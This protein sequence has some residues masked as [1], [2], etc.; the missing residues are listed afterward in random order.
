LCKDQYIKS[1][2]SPFVLRHYAG[3]F[4][5]FTYQND[6]RSWAR[7]N[8]AYGVFR[9]D[10]HAEVEDDSMWPWLKDFVASEGHELAS[11][12]LA[13]VGLLKPKVKVSSE[14][15]SMTTPA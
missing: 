4:D 1:P 15:S 12:L 2:V 13:D 8:E 7:S 9:A 5:Q 10:D 3:T 6:S 11:A 14:S